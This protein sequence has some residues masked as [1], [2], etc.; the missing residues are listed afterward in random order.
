M[1]MKIDHIQVIAE[2]M[3]NGFQARI[4]GDSRMW[5]RGDSIDEAVG[6]VIRNHF[7]VELEL[8]VLDQMKKRAA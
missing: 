3:G 6:S 5:G 4:N 2:P 1:S 8:C 7:W